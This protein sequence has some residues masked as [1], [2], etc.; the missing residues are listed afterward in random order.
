MLDAG[1]GDAAF[2]AMSPSDGEIEVA[3]VGIELTGDGGEHA[4]GA[5]FRA[6]R[7]VLTPG[8]EIG[9]NSG[10]SGHSR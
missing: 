4:D 9:D 3:G 10:S 1:H 8:N 2:A 6:D 5:Q 7:L